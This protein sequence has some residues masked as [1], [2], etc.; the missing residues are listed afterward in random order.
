MK[1]KWFIEVTMFLLTALYT[2][3]DLGNSE[4]ETIHFV[5]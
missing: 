3:R 1:K 2:H 4:M 5:V